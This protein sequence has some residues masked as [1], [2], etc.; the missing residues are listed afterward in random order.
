MTNMHLLEDTSS[1]LVEEES[2][3]D[4]TVP[5]TP[6]ILSQLEQQSSTIGASTNILTNNFLPR[7]SLK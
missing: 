2:S 6:Q 7:Q 4:L 1:A 5:M 3:I